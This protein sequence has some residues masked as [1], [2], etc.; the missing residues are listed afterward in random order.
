MLFLLSTACVKFIVSIIVGRLGMNTAHETASHRPEPAVLGLVA[1]SGWRLATAC[2]SAVGFGYE[3]GVG[4]GSLITG[5][6]P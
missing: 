2:V 1:F 3:M 5:M 6:L 4:V